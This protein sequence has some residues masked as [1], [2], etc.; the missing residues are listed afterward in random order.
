MYA[1]LESAVHFPLACSLSCIQSCR[2]TSD[3][4][5]PSLMPPALSPAS[6]G[7]AWRQQEAELLAALRL[8]AVQPPRDDPQ[9]LASLEA[10]CATH[11]LGLRRSAVDFVLLALRQRDAAEAE[12]EAAQA[13]ALRLEGALRGTRARLVEVS[14]AARA[15]HPTL[16]PSPP[17]RP[18]AHSAGAASLRA[19]AAEVPH[20]PRRVAILEA[21]LPPLSNAAQ[22][23]STSL[24]D[25]EKQ[26]SPKR[27]TFQLPRA[28]RGF[29]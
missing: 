9:L 12:R 15:A 23:W 1:R 7:E 13:D 28:S 10:T 26:G 27:P 16:R 3:G 11:L 5:P 18:R 22:R 25:E 2:T 24:R 6:F 20:T 19:V 8:A 17:G 29:S 14:A 4:F 21:H